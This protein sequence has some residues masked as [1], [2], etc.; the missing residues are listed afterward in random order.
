MLE[1][2]DSDR[3]KQLANRLE[4]EYSTKRDVHDRTKGKSF[5]TDDVRAVSLL[6]PVT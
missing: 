2:E 3:L 4:K 6:T 5:T 1:K